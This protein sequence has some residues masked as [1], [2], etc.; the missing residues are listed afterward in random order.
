MAIKL[1]I[2]ESVQ[3]ALAFERQEETTSI[4]AGT[5]GKIFGIPVHE[6]I[7]GD[8]KPIAEDPE[9]VRHFTK[10]AKVHKTKPAKFGKRAA[11]RR[12]YDP[13][14]VVKLA[15]QIA[16]GKIT[17]KQAAKELGVSVQAWYQAK[18]QYA[19]DLKKGVQ[20]QEEDSES[21]SPRQPVDLSLTEDELH[22]AIQGLKEDGLDSIRIAQKLKVSLKKV[23]EHW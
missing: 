8:D 5:V 1:F 17:T 21:E 22:A 6:T 9:P 18:A 4:H 14:E 2:F 16:A 11:D 7:S 23:N 10:P 13:E 20:R 15:Q 12:K 3:D 19:K